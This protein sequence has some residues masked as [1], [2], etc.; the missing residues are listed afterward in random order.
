MS[1]LSYTPTRLALRRSH[2]PAQGTGLRL[3]RAPVG[4]TCIMLLAITLAG[5]GMA[6]AAAAQP[7]VAANHA[8]ALQETEVRLPDESAQGENVAE[9]SATAPAAYSSTSFTN[10]GVNAKATTTANT[11][12]RST[13]NQP[14][15]ANVPEPG[16]VLVVGDS[17]SAAY[18]IQRAEG[19]VALLQNRLHNT[20]GSWR[21]ANASVSGET[22][23]GG[24]VRLAAELAAHKPDIVVL[25]LGGNDGLR[26]YPVSRI[27]ANLATMLEQIAGYT[28]KTLLLEMRI[29]PNY[30]P[31]YTKAFRDV[32]ATV[33]EQQ[34]VTLVPFFLNDVALEPGMMQNDGI[35]PSATAQP[36]LLEALW[37][38]LEP[39]L[40]TSN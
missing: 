4:S 33:A 6:T 14:A 26:G 27:R 36:M 28:S 3:W 5:T 25:E 15:A 37:P 39:L 23:G 21:V 2:W 31:R 8:T 35:H 32:F 38:Y 13:G 18:G 34:G 30:G 16:V 20:P 1:K 10:T 11:T 22:T 7:P 9:E 19:W 24:R 40:H 29:P 17:I 12:T